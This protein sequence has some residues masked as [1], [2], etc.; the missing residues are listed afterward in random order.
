MNGVVGSLYEASKGRRGI[1]AFSAAPLYTRANVLHGHGAAADRSAVQF[2]VYSGTLERL[3][4][5]TNDEY[6]DR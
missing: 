6:P 1:T 3:D 5:V 4:P 2:T